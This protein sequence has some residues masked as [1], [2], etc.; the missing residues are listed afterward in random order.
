MDKQY[1][2]MILKVIIVNA[3]M[4][5]YTY[6]HSYVRIVPN[7]KPINFVRIVNQEYYVGTAYVL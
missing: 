6:I 3:L 2:V 7:D 4:M 1:E 5:S